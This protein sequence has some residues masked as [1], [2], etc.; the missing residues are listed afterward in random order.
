M[1]FLKKI[2]YQA[3]GQKLNWQAIIVIM[4]VAVMIT[5]VLWPKK[6]TPQKNIKIAQEVKKEEKPQ[7]IGVSVGGFEQMAYIARLEKNYYDFEDRLKMM[8]KQVAGIK[9]STGEFSRNQKGINN[10]ILKLDEK[11]MK[12]IDGKIKEMDERLIAKENVSKDEMD[13]KNMELALADISLMVQKE[14]QEDTVY[15]PLGSFC[16]GTLLT[17]VYATADSANPLPVL[18]VLDEA[19]YGPNKTRIPLKGAF[20]LG[21]AYGDL[22][23]ERALI[24]IIAVS[25]V[26]PTTST[27]EHE[28]PLGYVTD[29]VGDLGLKGTVIRNTGRALAL[30]F[31][32]G[33]MAG[34]AKAMSDSETTVNRNRL[35]GTTQTVTGD[36]GKNIVSSGL[37]QSFAQFSQLKASPP[38]KYFLGTIC[39]VTGSCSSLM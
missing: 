35:G 12:A 29:Q 22:V 18:I 33:F 27:F 14:G 16:Q 10:A 28:Q 39:W 24:Q 6:E 3:D 37:A 30:S 20:I 36:R 31:M 32:S 7:A 15:L 9:E 17:G 4:A 19:F 25:S 34:G 2:L 5:A 1:V 13:E 23:S 21:K 8:E 38:E 26:L 11:I